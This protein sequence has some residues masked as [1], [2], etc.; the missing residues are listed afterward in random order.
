MEKKATD[1][2]V[3]AISSSRWSLYGILKSI[4]NY[5]RTT[6]GTQSNVDMK[7]FIKN[8]IY[9][10]LKINCLERFMIF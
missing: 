4:V 3:S 1:N 2:C 10:F 9:G 7:I 8:M 6:A 5:V